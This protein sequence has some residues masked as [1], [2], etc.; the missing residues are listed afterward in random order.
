MHLLTCDLDYFDTRHMTL[1]DPFD[2]RLFF[3]RVNASS[4]VV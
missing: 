2:E 4:S 1:F 3:I